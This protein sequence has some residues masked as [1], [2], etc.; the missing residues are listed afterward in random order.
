MYDTYLLTYLV[1]PLLLIFDGPIIPEII[2]GRPGLLYV[3]P[4]MNLQE[5]A[6]AAFLQVRLDLL[7]LRFIV[8]LKITHQTCMMKSHQ[9]NS[10]TAFKEA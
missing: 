4:Q 6:G 10:I 8:L 3:S 2:P 5:L 1:L 9:T 7:I